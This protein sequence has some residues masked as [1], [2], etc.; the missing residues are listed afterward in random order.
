M[1]T[2]SVT[3]SAQSSTR[4]I[5]AF[6]AMA[7]SMGQDPPVVVNQAYVENWMKQQLQSVVKQ[8]EHREDVQAIPIPPDIT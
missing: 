3:V 4:I 6:T 8:Y 2:L 1:P 5:T 7:N